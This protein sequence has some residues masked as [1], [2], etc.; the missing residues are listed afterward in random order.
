MTRQAKMTA[1][2]DDRIA[3]AFTD[4]ATPDIVAALIEETESAAR[5]AGERRQAAVSRL[6]EWLMD[7]Q[8][9]EEDD[10]RRAAYEGARAERDT[11]RR[12]RP[13]LPAARRA[14]GGPAR[15]ASC[16]RLSIRF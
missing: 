13:S 10:R 2:L 3:V 11:G 12:A 16:R 15:A 8:S 7:L 9:A 14:A 6:R 4:S 5:A 1:P